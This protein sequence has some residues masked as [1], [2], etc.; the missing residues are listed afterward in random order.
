LAQLQNLRYLNLYG[1][2]VTDAGLAHLHGLAKLRKLYLW[3][4]SVSYDV[5]MALQEKIP[6]LKVDLGFDHPVIVRQRLDKELERT[7]K[8]VEE[9]TAEEEKLTKELEQAK[10][11]KEAVQ[12]RLEEI[13]TELAAL[14]G[15]EAPAEEAKPAEE[16]K[17]EE[18][19]EK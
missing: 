9:T 2:G 8:Q 4:T 14:D 19:A 12:K 10:K 15:G 18:E 11:Q 7:T 1:T 13:N 16:E 6:G 3:Q 5:A 17:K